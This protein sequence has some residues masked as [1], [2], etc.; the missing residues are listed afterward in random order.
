MIEKLLDEVFLQTMMYGTTYVSV[1]WEDKE[2]KREVVTPPT[3]LLLG[4]A[5]GIGTVVRL[6][7]GQV[8]PV[9]ELSCH[10][11]A[12]EYPILLIDEDEELLLPHI[13]DIV[14]VF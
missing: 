7:Q 14:E 1:T 13:N 10:S 4:K 12:D 2:V 8:L 9:Y 3:I 5:V 11:S 6:K